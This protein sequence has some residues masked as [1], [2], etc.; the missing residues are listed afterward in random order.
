MTQKAGFTI[1]TRDSCKIPRG[2]GVP[3][4]KH[5]QDAR[6]TPVSKE[7]CKTLTIHRIH[8]VLLAV[9]SCASL[10]AQAT[11]PAQ[12]P[13][14]IRLLLPPRIYATPGIEMN[15][16]FDNICLVANPLNY[17]FDVNCAKGS[18]QTERW[19]FVPTEEDVGQYPFVIEV[20][21]ETNAV[22]ARA[23]SVLQVAPKT[24]GAGLPISVLTIGDS[25][26]HA[27]VYPAHLLELCKAEGNPKITLVGHVPNEKTPDVRIEGYGGWTAH[28]F[29]TFYKEGERRN[30]TEDWKTWNSS[31]SPFL[32]ADGTGKP[33]LD[34]PRYCR[35]FNGGKAPD[36]VTFLLGCND[37]FGANDETIE[38]SI[39]TMFKYYD[40]LIEMV[41]QTRADTKIGMLLLVPPV[42]T[43]DG[44]GANYK[45][46]QTR[47]QYK[48]NQQRVVERTMEKY[49]KREKE[50]IFLIPSNVN[51]D[52]LHNYPSVN[53]P[54]NSQTKAEGRRLNNGVHPAPEGYRQIGDTIF[55]WIKA[56]LAAAPVS[57][58]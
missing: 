56:Q 6:A 42:G 5:G 27:A 22:I 23:E 4:M 37:N 52:C 38:A 43:Q 41:R 26:T 44:F 17:L 12:F 58:K 20:R 32:Y 57:G 36:F 34:F 19:T 11:V 21:N 29:A 28:R 16:Y 47:W 51:L 33:A 46:G 13:G 8:V 25:L 30:G 3:P 48:R 55:C 15:V 39:D 24:A 50:N 49:G 7:V 1:K 53:A 14:A 54:W 9:L 45:C 2:M 35:E 40:M 31:G 10:L 18:Q